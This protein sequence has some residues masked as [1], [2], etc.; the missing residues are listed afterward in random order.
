M[1]QALEARWYEKL[2]PLMER[3]RERAESL[4][5]DLADFTCLSVDG[6]EWGAICMNC[7][8]WVYVRPDE[9]E[10]KLLTQ[11]VGRRGRHL[12]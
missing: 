7:M 4:D 3:V 1:Q 9:A 10:G 6:E 5:H 8:Q 12:L 2:Q 11:C